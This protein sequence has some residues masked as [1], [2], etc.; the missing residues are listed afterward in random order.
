[1]MSRSQQTALAATAQRSV[2]E[3]TRDFQNQLNEYG[4]NLAQALPHGVTLEKFKRVALTATALNPDLLRADR[5][6]LFLAL[7][8]AAADGLMPDGRECALVIYNTEVKHRDP[9]TGLDQR[10]RI[11]AVQYMPMVSGIRERMR[12]TGEV[13][14][15]DA[16]VVHE[17]DHFKYVLGDHA[18]IEHE[19]PP[20]G[21]DRGKV[22]GA[23]AIIK[24]K[25][26]EVLR[27][28]MSVKD[29]ETTRSVSRAKDGPMWTK[30]YGEA[31]RK[32]VLRRCAKAA[33]QTAELEE[34]LSRA[35]EPPIL[36]EPGDFERLE[37]MEMEPVREDPTPPPEPMEASD[38]PLPG[39]QPSSESRGIA[40]PQL[41]SGKPDYRAWAFGLFLPQVR[42][43]TSS[44]DLALL[45]GDNEAELATA[46]R[47]LA[48]G[49]LRELEALI[50]QRW[51]EIAEMEK[52][53]A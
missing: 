10:F 7:S 40:V 52:E 33:P 19:P 6:T 44:A 31:A 14:S 16:Q 51:D 25:N 13:T 11:D 49:D 8:K 42:Q 38:I 36:P 29:I 18:R 9:A 28:V 45:C 35:D 50:T 47:H 30:F 48:A 1:M 53:T 3:R 27:D 17:K 34:L 39:D 15:A 41:P 43:M 22:V 2:V 23:Y 46:K 24:L 21:Q 37:P 12:R 4:G 32:T 20:L 5:R 26:G